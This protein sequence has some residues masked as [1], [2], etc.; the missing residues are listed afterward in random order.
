MQNRPIKNSLHINCVLNTIK[1]AIILSKLKRDKFQTD[2]RQNRR[3]VD[4]SHV[5]SSR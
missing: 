4:E 3:Y 5:C 1:R 2:Y